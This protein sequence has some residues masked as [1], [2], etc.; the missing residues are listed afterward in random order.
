MV[1]AVTPVEP[2]EG[3]ATVT[4]GAAVYPVPF[5]TIVNPVTFPPEIIAVAVAVVPGP[6]EGAAIVTVG[7]VA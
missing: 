7:A 6:G 3:A 4:I 5:T 1:K 2:P